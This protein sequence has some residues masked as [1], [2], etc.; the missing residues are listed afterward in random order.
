M[1]PPLAHA[2]KSQLGP[3]LLPF[4][5]VVDAKS[6]HVSSWD[7]CLI[8]YYCGFVGYILSYHHDQHI[9]SVDVSSIQIWEVLSSGMNDIHVAF[10]IYTL[11]SF[12]SNQALSKHS[13]H[14]NPVVQNLFFSMVRLP[15]WTAHFW[16]NQSRWQLDDTGG[17]MVLDG[18]G[19]CWMVLDDVGW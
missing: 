3:E 2:R 14:L 6:A 1:P 7:R 8:V 4:W 11:W 15:L 9:F 13:G 18:V 10:L 16:S 17:W 5:S 19:W 12:M